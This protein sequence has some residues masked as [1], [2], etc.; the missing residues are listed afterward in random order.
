MDNNQSVTNKIV[1]D[2]LIVSGIILLLLLIFCFFDLYMIPLGFVLGILISLANYAIINVQGKMMVNTKTKTP[3]VGLIMICY[4]S[5]FVLYGVGLF[6]AFYLEYIGIKLFAWY[7][8]FVG[9]MIIKA[10]IFFKYN[11]KAISDESEER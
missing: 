2:T 3:N 5:R 7:S 8:V 10:V 9:Y 11:T 1:I 6:L 4:I